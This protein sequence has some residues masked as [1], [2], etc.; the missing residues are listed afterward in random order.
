M[1]E[2]HNPGN[3][4]NQGDNPKPDKQGFDPGG[5]L[6]RLR[7]WLSSVFCRLGSWSASF[8][9]WAPSLSV[10]GALRGFRVCVAGAYLSPL[11]RRDGGA[12]RAEGI[13]LVFSE[14][15]GIVRILYKLH[16]GSILYVRN[17]RLTLV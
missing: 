10:S 12:R 4:E 7:I 11:R 3:A 16:L 15:D 13:L 14:V 6:L 8:R 5:T 17:A 1:P 2:T 9:C